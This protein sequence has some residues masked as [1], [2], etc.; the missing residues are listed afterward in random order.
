MR[1]ATQPAELNL[2]TAR[3][4]H[5][6]LSSRPDSDSRR[7]HGNHQTG[8]PGDEQPE[9]FPGFPPIGP[10][11]MSNPRCPPEHHHVMSALR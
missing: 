2:N 5:Y 11:N 4:F 9:I 1:C 3:T 8:S 7:Q 10:A 6:P